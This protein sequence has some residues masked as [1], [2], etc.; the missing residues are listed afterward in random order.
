VGIAVGYDLL[1]FCDKKVNTNGCLI[2]KL[3][4]KGKSY[5]KVYELKQKQIT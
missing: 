4:I 2:L 3:I 5:K 1:G